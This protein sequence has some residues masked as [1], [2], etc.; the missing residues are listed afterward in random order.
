MN[1]EMIYQIKH[2]DAK[3]VLVHPSA[4]KNLNIA[5]QSL[6]LTK[7]RVFFFSDVEIAEFEGIR[8]WRST[9]GTADEAYNWPWQRLSH[10]ES[11]T[12][13]ATINYSSGCANSSACYR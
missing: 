1:S 11:K 7:T 5:L 10:E 8:D 3:M 13:I 4:A 9:I 6:K 12:R 2:I